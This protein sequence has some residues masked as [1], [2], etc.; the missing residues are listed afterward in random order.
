M[1]TSTEIKT[2]IDTDITDKVTASSISPTNVGT[3]MKDVVDYVDQEK[4]PY[5]VYTA[6]LT[7]TG[8]AAPVAT[9]FEN[10]LG[11][12]TWTRNF[13]GD[14]FATISGGNTF[15]VNKTLCL[16]ERHI[17]NH[18]PAGQFWQAYTDRFDA[19]RIRLFTYVDDIGTDE[20]IYNLF[21]EF[22]VYN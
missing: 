9:V 12:I 4:R 14:Y 21:V 15:I 3:R 16:P 13:A 7:Q 20:I 8:T 10:T 2:N 18:G 11:T 22:R 1:E 6:F 17:I 19:T 5:K